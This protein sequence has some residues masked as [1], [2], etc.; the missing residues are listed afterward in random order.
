[1]RAVSLIVEKPLCLIGYNQTKKESMINARQVR[2][3][4][5]PKK[6]KQPFVDI[7][8]NSFKNICDD[9]LCD[10]SL[11]AITGRALMSA[12]TLP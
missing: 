12:S 6:R 8:N 11:I 1:M 9:K 5:Y 10:R 4:L 2:E 7:A 3:K